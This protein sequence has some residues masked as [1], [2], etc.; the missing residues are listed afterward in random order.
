M[1]IL[2]A[3]RRSSKESVLRG[4]RELLDGSLNGIVGWLFDSFVI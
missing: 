4:E 2:P 1:G 3:K